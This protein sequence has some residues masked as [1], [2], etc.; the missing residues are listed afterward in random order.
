SLASRLTRLPSRGED[1]GQHCSGSKRAI[2]WAA[3]PATTQRLALMKQLCTLLFTLLVLACSDQS[4][5]DSAMPPVDTPAENV[6][7]VGTW[8]A[9]P[10][11]TEPDNN[12]P[13]PGLADN[14]LRQFAY[15]SLGG[16]QLRLQISNE[17]GDGPVTLKAVHVAQ[18]KSAPAI[19]E[20]TDVA[21]AFSGSSDVTIPAGEA[22]YSDPFEF[23]LAEQSTVAVTMHLGD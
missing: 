4:S 11:L 17:F 1:R 22:V 16:D 7:W 5:E 15:V 18:V 12:P 23:R 6:K 13:E 3:T 21:V 10:Q 20:S 9:S 14:T 8:G 2:A 19:E